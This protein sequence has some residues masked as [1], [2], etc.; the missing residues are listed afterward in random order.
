MPIYEYSGL[1]KGGKNS[2]GT[3]D[4]DSIRAARQKLRSQGVFPTD[5]KEALERS[6]TTTK[7]IKSFFQSDRV[8]LK[9]LAIATRQ[10]S[11]LV[12]AGLPLVEAL[13][14]LSEQVESVV[15]KRIIINV[16]ENIQE[17]S[18]L[19]KALAAFPKAFPRL[20]INMVK[21]GEASGTLDVVLEN[22]ADYL[23]AQNEL[24]RKITSSLFYPALMLFFCTAIV[25]VLL[26]WVVPTIVEIFIKQ[27][28]VLPFPTRVMLAISNCLTN[29]WYL[30]I[31]VGAILVLS[32]R[33][34]YSKDSGRS[35]IHRILL[36]LPLY[37]A[38][39]VKIATARVARTLGTLLT[40]GVGLLEALDISKNI[41][42]NLHLAAALD[43]SRE[44]VQQ[45]RSLAKELKSTQEFPPML[46]HMV[47]A[48]ES[49]GRLESMLVKAGK[50]YEN[51]VN[52]TLSGLTSLIEPIMMI[53]L[54]GIV[55]SIVMSILLPM[56]DLVT[57][58]QK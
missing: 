53:I 37:G 22:L 17:G 42:S 34:Y 47:A 15:L 39:T 51:E 55:L 54:G 40:N 50:A 41:V 43:S 7:D 30:I 35:R 52:A 5:I 21:A 38:L 56:I 4:A 10:L 28:A 12:G 26:T 9:D 23:E 19:A 14:A 45:G 49:S 29:Y 44:G 11:T 20:Y 33:I 58:I 48:G 25:V 31:L 32:T 2:K 27:G 46:V 3:V 6:K 1:D 18:S 13:Q 57:I 16:R 24:R 8:G 36:K